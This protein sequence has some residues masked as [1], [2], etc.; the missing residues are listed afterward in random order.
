MP[1]FDPIYSFSY[2]RVI[3]LSFPESAFSAWQVNFCFFV[4]RD[5]DSFILEIIG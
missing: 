2:S 1:P 3:F 5:I 4:F